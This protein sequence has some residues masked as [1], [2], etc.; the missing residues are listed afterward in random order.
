MTITRITFIKVIISSL[1]LAPWVPMP[2]GFPMLRPEWFILILGLVALKTKYSAL[3]NINIFLAMCLV[4]V[5]ILSM[6]LGVTFMGVHFD[7]KD[8][9]VIMPP[10]LYSFFYVLS[11]SSLY[12]FKSIKSILFFTYFV[13]SVAAFISIIQFFDPRPVEPILH[14]FTDKERTDSYILGRTTGTMGNPNDLGF[15]FLIGFSLIIFSGEYVI[16]SKFLLL[17]IE[18]TLFFAVISTGSRT[19]YIGLAVIL[20]VH[21]WLKVRRNFSRLLQM[22]LMIF[23]SV[24]FFQKYI[25]NSDTFKT[26]SERILSISFIEEDAALTDRINAANETMPL[27]Y[28]SW[29]IGRGPN[30][31]GFVAGANV[32]NEYVL[33]LYRF[34]L[35]GTVLTIIYV[36]FLAF[37]KRPPKQI[38]NHLE[39]SLH[40]FTIAIIIAGAIFAYTAGLFMAFR[41][42]GLLITLWT[43]SAKISDVQQNIA[44]QPI[45]DDSYAKRKKL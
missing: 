31:L 21:F 37:Q 5:Y 26:T 36:A 34:G 14:L 39:N 35:I 40:Q 9:T 24:L 43:V 2:T 23:L 15:L 25:A 29:L 8:L 30:K 33:F 12:S 38:R 44:L 42:M 16:K 20:F 11:A 32:D 17:A 13:F 18:I 10:V 3:N 41:L 4:I 22:M 1:I 45:V 28:E 7:A 6:F 27:I 19:A